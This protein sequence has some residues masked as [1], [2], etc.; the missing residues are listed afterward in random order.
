MAPNEKCQVENSMLEEQLNTKQV[1]HSKRLL[2]SSR[3]VSRSQKN[4]T[5]SLKKKG[6]PPEILPPSSVL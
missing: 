1:N 4:G 5:N 6:N 2:A 3:Y